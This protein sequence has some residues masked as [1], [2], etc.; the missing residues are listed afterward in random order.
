MKFAERESVAG[1]ILKGNLGEVPFG[2]VSLN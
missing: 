1:K 2:V